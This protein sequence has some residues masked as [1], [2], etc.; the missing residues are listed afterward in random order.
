MSFYDHVYPYLLTIV[1][2]AIAILVGVA[3]MVI[4]IKYLDYQLASSREDGEDKRVEFS[5]CVG[6]LCAGVIFLAYATWQLWAALGSPFHLIHSLW[7][8]LWVATLVAI[9]WLF[10]EVRAHSWWVSTYL[11]VYPRQTI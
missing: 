9:Y 10:S 7:T 11:R 8:L 1:W 2:M 6:G 4:L 3:V 5:F